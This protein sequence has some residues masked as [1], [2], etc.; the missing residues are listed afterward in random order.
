MKQTARSIYENSFFRYVVIGGSTFAIDFFVLIT[1]HGALRVNVLISATISYWLSI[2]YNFL[3]NRYWTFKIKGEKDIYKHIIL[4]AL[5]LGFNYLF[6]ITFMAFAIHTL[7]INYIVSKILA[8][9]FQI[10]WT[11]IIYKKI[12]FKPENNE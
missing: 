9:A 4:Y 8:V 10:T 11:Y 1:L 2:A 5:L 7:N 12:I 3:L 6:T